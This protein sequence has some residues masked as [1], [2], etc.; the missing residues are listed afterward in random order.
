[1]A[2]KGVGEVLEGAN[3]CHWAPDE[4]AEI[5]PQVQT[6]TLLYYWG[7]W[8]TKNLKNGGG[9]IPISPLRGRGVRKFERMERSGFGR[10][11]ALEGR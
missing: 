1:M 6:V 3:P 9:Q 7:H 2:W 5:D 10:R 11:R 8:V 4:F